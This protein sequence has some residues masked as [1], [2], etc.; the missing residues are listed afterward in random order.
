[1]QCVLRGKQFQATAPTPRF[2]KTPQR[3]RPFDVSHAACCCLL[4][5]PN[6]T[7]LKRPTCCRPLVVVSPSNQTTRRSNAPLVVVRLLLSLP[8]V[9]AAPRGAV[10][11]EWIVNEET[12]A[13]I[14]RRE[15]PRKRGLA[16]IPD[17]PHYPKRQLQNLQVVPSVP[18]PTDSESGRD[19]TLRRRGRRRDGVLQLPPKLKT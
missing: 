9:S 3:I 15:A 11:S 17:L 12:V 16:F 10:L 1:M 18:S 8:N 14:S 4:P 7:A 19:V 13:P 2:G 6:D 5:Q